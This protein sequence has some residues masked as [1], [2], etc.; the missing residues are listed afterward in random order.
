MY[1]ITLQT[2]A[3]HTLQ[4]T[5]PSNVSK[6]YALNVISAQQHWLQVLQRTE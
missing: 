2:A 4:L 3:I 1:D 6:A 5:Q